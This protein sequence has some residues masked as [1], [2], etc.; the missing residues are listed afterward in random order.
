MQL[1]PNF[2]WIKLKNLRKLYFR[3]VDGI[4]EN[5]LKKIL[6]QRN[7]DQCKDDFIEIKYNENEPFRFFAKMN[8]IIHSWDIDFRSKLVTATKTLNVPSNSLIIISN[9]IFSAF[10]LLSIKFYVYVGIQTEILD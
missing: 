5:N 4:M 7:N 1:D 9:N 2:D 10:F 3:Y 6:Q 8:G